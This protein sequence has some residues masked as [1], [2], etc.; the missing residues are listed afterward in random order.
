MANALLITYVKPVVASV[1]TSGAAPVQVQTKPRSAS[2]ASRSASGSRSGSVSEHNPQSFQSTAKRTSTSSLHDQILALEQLKEK[3][4]QE[5]N[6]S[7][8]PRRYKER[9]TWAKDYIP[10]VGKHHKR[11]GAPGGGANGGGFSEATK[12]SS[13][14]IT[15]FMPRNDFNNVITAWIWANVDGVKK[16]YMDI[17]NV[18][19]CIE[20]ELKVGQVWEKVKDRRLQLPIN[21]ETVLSVDF[22][23]SD[24]FF[25][26]GMPLQ[27]Y[28]DI[29]SYLTKLSQDSNSGNQ[30]GVSGGATKALVGA[31]S[32]NKFV[33]ETSHVVD[34]IASESKR[35]D[36]PITGRVSVD[37]K[38]KRKMASI[39][40]QRIADIIL[41]QP[42]SLFDL[43]LSI[44]V[45]ER[46][47]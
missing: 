34:L 43:R 30:P 11:G 22:F 12:L 41:F 3:K 45:E 37:V 39:Q 20:L 19:Q 17:P 10:T 24:C 38:T 46:K 23:N 26:S 28:H 27:E 25:K 42:N 21:T 44:L 33:V 5:A 40:K 35:N 6:G 15:G 31:S 32:G 36:R 14:S 47:R 8:K 7:G 4:E 9:P 18:E 13:P 29:K 1:V 2:T 16:D